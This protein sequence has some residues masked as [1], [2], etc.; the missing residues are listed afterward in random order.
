[1]GPNEF[2][3]GEHICVV[4]QTAEEQRAVAADYLSDGLRRGERVYYVADSAESLELFHRA[5]SRR[6]IDVATALQTTALVEATH[7]EAH[8]V[9]GCFDSERMLRLLN[10]GIEAAVAAGF[11]GLRTCGD[12]SWLLGNPAGAEQVV[13]YE[14]LLNNLF[15]GAPACGMCQY[16]ASRLP[17]RFLDHGLA[18]HSTVVI[19]GH[20]KSNPYYR[21]SAVASHPIGHEDDVRWKVRELRRH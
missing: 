1:M 20:H 6:G 16:D 18:T 3:Q 8:L 13:E 9:D 14:A 10:I 4:Y 12:M 2:H 5:L 7:A 19:D 11:S 17:A 21:P 15:L